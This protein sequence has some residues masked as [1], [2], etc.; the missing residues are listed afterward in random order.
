LAEDRDPVS[1]ILVRIYG[2]ARQTILGLVD[3]PQHLHPAMMFRFLGGLLLASIG[4]AG[5]AR[6]R[7]HRPEGAY[8]QVL[9]NNKNM[10]YHADFTMGGQKIQGLFD[11]GSFELVVR[12]T[13]CAHCKHPTAAYDHTKSKTYKLN[14]TT[15]Q[16][17]YGSG[18]CV[19]VMEYDEVCVGH[20][21]SPQQSFW[22][23]T[24]HRIPVLDQATFAAIVG[25][26]P[27]FGFG[28]KEQTLLM[29][30]GIDEFSICL[31]KESGADGFLTWGTIATPAEKKASFITT[32][33]IGE[34][35]WT[36]TMTDINFG[37]PTAAGQKIVC[38]PGECAA[39]IDSGTS[40][41][42]AP[43]EHLMQLSAL[44]SAAVPSIA[45]DCSNMH[46]LP[47]LHFTMG[48]G[49]HFTLPP[50]AYIMRLTGATVEASNIWDVLFF[51]PKIKKLNTC[52]PAFM[53]MD[54]P[55]E[56][57]MLWILGMPFFRHY[58]SSFDRVNKEMHFAK[59]GPGCEPQP[60]VLN[61]TALI[62]TPSVGDF[63]PFDVDLR[64]VI[65]PT[66]GF[67]IEK[68]LVNMVV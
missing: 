27:S 54:M 52:M 67:P 14:G 44:L 47:T 37:A 25:I 68:K 7:A 57:G 4:L 38:A 60:L 11:T 49:K 55:S 31:Q 3:S 16:H 18:P 32:P 13:R 23:I 56:H 30:Y 33:S 65:P 42:A 40:L 53:Q 66:F 61:K 5:A 29:S 6:F 17:V 63:E 10:A 15:E 43:R 46:L 9:H 1:A 22:E 26:G 62:A 8:R 45:E 58:H 48:D 12:G 35:H 64:E 59:A 20:M 39:I 36:A 2:I 34:H 51:K 28:N 19:S 50:S 21:C 24:D 41:I